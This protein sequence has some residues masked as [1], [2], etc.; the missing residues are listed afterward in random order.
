ML[1]GDVGVVNFGPRT[2]P[3]R[4]KYWAERGLIHYENTETNE[5]DTLTVREFLLRLK[6]INDMLG[7]S[8]A[9]L[10]SAKFAHADEIKRQQK[11]VEEASM[12]A[13]KAQQQ[14]MPSDP[15]ARAEAKRRAPKSVVVPGGKYSF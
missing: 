15:Q 7:N 1:I 4:D 10:A 2:N 11:F 9:T 5:Y 3:G 14:G 6:A 12:L 8:R 13:R